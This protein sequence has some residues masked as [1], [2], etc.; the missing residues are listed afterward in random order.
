M[1]LIPADPT[2]EWPVIYGPLRLLAWALLDRNGF[3]P[4]TLY[5]RF[6]NHVFRN[7]VLDVKPEDEFKKMFLVDMNEGRI[8]EDI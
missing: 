3:T 8:I 1:N 2:R 7:G 5:L 6:R 4:I